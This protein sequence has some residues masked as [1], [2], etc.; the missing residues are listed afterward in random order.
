MAL[1][2]A[3][4]GRD[5]GWSKVHRAVPGVGLAW[6]VCVDGPT[7]LTATTAGTR[8]ATSAMANRAIILVFM[9]VPMRNSVSCDITQH[10]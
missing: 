10:F 9:F 8:A 1:G 6:L 2:D 7:A 5:V 3:W 4:G